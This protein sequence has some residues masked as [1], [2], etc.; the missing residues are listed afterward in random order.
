MTLVV[1]LKSVYHYNPKEQSELG[2]GILALAEIRT[3]FSGAF[4]VV[5]ES[6]TLYVAQ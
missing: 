4:H 2:W 3:S 1:A 5:Q 6:T